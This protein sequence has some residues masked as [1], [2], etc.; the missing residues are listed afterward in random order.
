VSVE[1]REESSVQY[2]VSMKKTRSSEK[3]QRKRSCLGASSSHISDC[4]RSF[5]YQRIQEGNDLAQSMR[6]AVSIC[7]FNVVFQHILRASAI[8]TL[9]TE[10]I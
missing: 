8:A 7:L 9:E 5:H 1:C 4:Q 6:I 10:H 3:D 2:N